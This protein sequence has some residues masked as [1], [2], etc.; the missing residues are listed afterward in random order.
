MSDPLDEA[1]WRD[2]PDLPVSRRARRTR[3]ALGC[4]LL[5]A[6]LVALVWFALTHLHIGQRGPFGWGPG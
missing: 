5:L 3:I 6:I 2:R 4:L 1:L